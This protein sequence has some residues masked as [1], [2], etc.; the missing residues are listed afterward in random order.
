[1]NHASLRAVAIAMV[2]AVAT[3]CSKPAAQPLGAENAWIR[4][5]PPGAEVMGGFLTLRNNSDHPI[6]CTAISSPDFGAIE[7]HR[8]VVEDGQSRMLHEDALELPPGGSAQLA[9]GGQHLMLF[10]PQ[11]PIAAG[12]TARLDFD[13][14]DERLTV[15][16]TVRAG[17]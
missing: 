13:C 2:V 9:P 14:G 1:M 10:R 11:R 6:R 4:E 5:A 15:V 16:F 7:I 8:T 12:D 17:A 3:A